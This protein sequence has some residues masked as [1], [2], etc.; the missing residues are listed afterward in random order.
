MSRLALTKDDNVQ[1]TK[2]PARQKAGAEHLALI[3][4]NESGQS[5]K[6][7][8][9]DLS[10]SAGKVAALLKQSGVQNGDA[11]GIYMPM[12]PEVLAVLFGCFKIGAVAVPVFSGFGAQA[13]S[14]RMLDAKVK[15][16]FTADGGKRRGKLLEIKK[17]VDSIRNSVPSLKHVIVIKYCEN[18][19]DWQA[20]DIWFHDA[21]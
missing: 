12:V 5:K 19:I 16:V 6:V 3:W 15:V 9:G 21:P 7:T 2:K 11:V 13:L 10:I 4:E 1:T 17:D 8:Y 18:K 14:K 20:G